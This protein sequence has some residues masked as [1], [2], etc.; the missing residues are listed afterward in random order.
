MKQKLFV[1]TELIALAIVFG[2]SVIVWFTQDYFKQYSPMW[3]V[4]IVQPVVTFVVLTA[5]NWGW[6]WNRKRSDFYW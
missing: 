3:F 1:V 4:W 6:T 2:L 5:I